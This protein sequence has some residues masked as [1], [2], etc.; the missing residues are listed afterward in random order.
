ME[1]NPYMS[2]W[3][4]NFHNR[5]ANEKA[6]AAKRREEKKRLKAEAHAER[7]R[8]KEIRDKELGYKK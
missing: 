7:L 2:I 4:G 3:N 5:I 8:L 1:H 6:D